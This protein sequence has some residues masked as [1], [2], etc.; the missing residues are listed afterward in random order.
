M[1]VI[2]RNVNHNVRHAIKFH[3]F[4]LNAQISLKIQLM[5]HVK[6]AYLGII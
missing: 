3:P 6:S 2:V 5:E 4:V 1:M